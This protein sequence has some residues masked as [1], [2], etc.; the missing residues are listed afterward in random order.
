MA[1]FPTSPSTGTTT[2]INGMTYVY[3]AHDAWEIASTQSD[4]TLVD[5]GVSTFVAQSSSPTAIAG[6]ALLYAKEAAGSPTSNLLMHF[7]D[8]LTDEG[9]IGATVTHPGT[10][11]GAPVYS[12]TSKFGSHA[13]HLDTTSGGDFLVIPTDSELQFDGDFTVDFWMKWGSAAQSGGNVNTSIISSAVSTSGLAYHTTA[14]AGISLTWYKTTANNYKRSFQLYMARSGHSSGFEHAGARFEYYGSGTNPAHVSDADL[15]SD[16][17][18]IAICRTSGVVEMWLNG[19]LLTEAGITNSDG[20]STNLV[21][22]ATING[23]N[24]DYYIGRERYWTNVAT[25]NTNNHDGDFDGYIDELRFIK[26]S[27]EFS[28]AT[29]TPPASAYSST[30]ASVT[31]LHVMDSSGSED[32]VT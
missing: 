9:S 6:K 2:V 15:V 10:Y 26:G 18:H 12:S 8:S 19:I 28:G 31:K 13:L 29:F 25:D 23:A 27:A 24:V 20:S 5:V 22:T 7:N 16:F 4:E 14:N 11:N 32:I 21:T 30:G 1:V 3:N 17:H